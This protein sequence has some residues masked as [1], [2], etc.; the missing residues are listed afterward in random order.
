M[1]S[2][3]HLPHVEELLLQ[4]R[5]GIVQVNAVFE[6]C[7]KPWHSI[8]IKMDGSPSVLAGYDP[9]D[10][11]FFVATKSIFNKEPVVFKSIKE[12]CARYSGDL[13][14]KMILAFYLLQKAGIGGI[15]Q[16]DFLFSQFDLKREQFC[17]HEY[18]TFQPNTIVYG[19]P[20]GSQQGRDILNARIGIAWHTRYEGPLTEL[21]AH[22]DPRIAESLQPVPGLYN[23]S[24]ALPRDLM[25][26]SAA[27]LKEMLAEFNQRA[28]KYASTDYTDVLSNQDLVDSVRKHMNA[29]VMSGS[30]EVVLTSKT[31]WYDLVR[32]VGAQ[33][34]TKRSELKTARGKLARDQRHNEL[35]V[36]IAAHTPFLLDLFDLMRHVIKMKELVLQKAD[37]IGPYPFCTF[38]RGHGGVLEPTGH[39]GYVVKGAKLVDRGEFSRV[40]FGYGGP[41]KRLAK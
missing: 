20:I 32:Y 15:I 34:H 6:E 14:S 29:R 23:V 7:Q 41:N 37:A 27:R 3:I 36:A 8:S 18:V 10:G 11:Q 22:P 39:E 4:G 17:G 31:H 26:E 33:H 28:N 16:G 12:I 9:A 2:Q 1:A 40:N 24:T 5:A 21:R 19:A 25:G 38:F 30:R 35:R 13:A